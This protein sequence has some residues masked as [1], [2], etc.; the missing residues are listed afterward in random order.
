MG[1]LILIHSNQLPYQCI[2]IYLESWLLICSQKKNYFLLTFVSNVVFYSLKYNTYH[3]PFIVWWFLWDCT[4]QII[5][6]MK[7]SGGHS[8]VLLYRSAA[9]LNNLYPG[10][11][12]VSGLLQC[13]WLISFCFSP[14]LTGETDSKFTIH[15]L[16]KQ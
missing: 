12:T 15:N 6:K 16:R 1:I 13:K 4:M 2:K 3:I 7:S 10:S 11:F 14:S 9:L 5:L 8:T